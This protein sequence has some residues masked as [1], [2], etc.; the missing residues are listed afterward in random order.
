MTPFKELVSPV[1]S[2]GASKGQWPF[3]VAAGD[4]HLSALLLR[5]S[6]PGMDSSSGFNMYREPAY[7][8][9]L[10]I[11]DQHT[12]LLNMLRSPIFALGSLGVGNRP[13]ADSHHTIGISATPPSLWPGCELQKY[14]LRSTGRQLKRK[15]KTKANMDNSCFLKKLFQKKSL[16]YTS[17][18]KRP[19]HSIQDNSVIKM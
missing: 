4:P 17:P 8:L 10:S 2:V 14:L 1:G 15:S 9:V 5:A 6:C 18:R 7:L 13:A 19:F 3:E 16:L 12:G 11:T